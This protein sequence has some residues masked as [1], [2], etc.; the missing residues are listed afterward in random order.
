[1]LDGIRLLRIDAVSTARATL[2]AMP[3][4]GFADKAA[5]R[6]EIG[7]WTDRSR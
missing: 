1:M 7:D 2:S 3:L 6:M 5:V 4:D